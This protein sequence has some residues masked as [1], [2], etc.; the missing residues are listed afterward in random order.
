VRHANQLLAP[1][2]LS[3]EANRLDWGTLEACVP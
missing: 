1:F 3:F 2:E